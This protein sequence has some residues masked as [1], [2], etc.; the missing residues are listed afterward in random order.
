MVDVTMFTLHLLLAVFS[1]SVKLSSF[2]LALKV[3][4]ILHYSHL[5]ANLMFAVCPKT[6]LNISTVA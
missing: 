6:I 5:H 3:R 1:F 4:I 2:M